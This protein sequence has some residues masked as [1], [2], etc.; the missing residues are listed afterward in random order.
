MGTGKD[1][2][3]MDDVDVM[4]CAAARD[5][6]YTAQRELMFDWIDNDAVPTKNCKCVPAFENP[7]TC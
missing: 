2:V 3:R 6:I 7:S 5:K 4:A 1:W